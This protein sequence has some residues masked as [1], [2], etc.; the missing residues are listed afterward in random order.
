MELAPFAPSAP[1]GE[2]GPFCVLMKG[3]EEGESGLSMKL[4]AMK[5][6]MTMAINMKIRMDVTK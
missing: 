4:T 2:L 5:T 1:D 6:K 3:K